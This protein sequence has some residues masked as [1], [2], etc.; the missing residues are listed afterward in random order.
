MKIIELT[1]EL[2]EDT[3]IS[4]NAATEGGHKS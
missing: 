4:E 1:I 2:K 3:V